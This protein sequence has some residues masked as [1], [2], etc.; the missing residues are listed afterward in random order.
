MLLA[1]LGALARLDGTREPDRPAGRPVELLGDGPIHDAVAAELLRKPHTVLVTV[2]RDAHWACDHTLGY[3]VPDR[4]ARYL[5]GIHP[6]CAFP[7]CDIPA[8]RCDGDHAIPW[9]TGP[10]CACNLIP[11][12]RYHHRLK[13]HTRWRVTLHRNRRVEWISPTGRRYLVRRDLDSDGEPADPPEKGS[14]PTQP[15]RACRSAETG[16]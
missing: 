6:R 11:L 5:T 8:H 10:T 13:T 7:G 16:I 14:A 15:Y 12:C 2:D 1:D 4:L 9:P 3:Q